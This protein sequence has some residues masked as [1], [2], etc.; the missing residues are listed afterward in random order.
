MTEANKNSLKHVWLWVYCIFLPIFLTG[1]FFG[2]PVVNGIINN[3]NFTC[4]FL[5]IA[6]LL[7]GLMDTLVHHFGTSILKSLNPLF[8]DA[9]IS[10][11]NKYID[12]DPSKGRTLLPV[13][14]TDAWHFVKIIFISMI[15]MACVFYK[16][17]I[18]INETVNSFNQLFVNTVALFSFFSWGF[19]LAYDFILPKK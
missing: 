9:S 19:I 6:G 12:R 10:W 18:T 8:W 14:L 17:I 15:V 13:M 5:F 4:L 11:K 7:N 3:G 16:P 2:K 1:W